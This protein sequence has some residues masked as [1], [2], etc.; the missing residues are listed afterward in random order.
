M[1]M[2]KMKTKRARRVAVNK[3]S[4]ELIRP[5]FP[6]PFELWSITLVY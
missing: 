1:V 4:L 2:K 6:L 3:G 5:L